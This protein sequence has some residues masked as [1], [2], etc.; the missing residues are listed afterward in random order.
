MARTRN[1]CKVNS[2]KYITGEL[3]IQ[4][5]LIEKRGRKSNLTKMMEKHAL[6]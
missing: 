6:F 3:S 5:N 2:F 1:L 4:P